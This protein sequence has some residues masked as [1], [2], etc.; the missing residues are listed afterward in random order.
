MATVVI[1]FWLCTYYNVIISWAM[2][3]LFS[4]FQSVL[5]WI[6]CDNEWNTDHCFDINAKN[7]TDAGPNDTKV[8]SSQEFYE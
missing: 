1:S 3:Y 5:P 8:S 4:S 6:G 7:R 2:I